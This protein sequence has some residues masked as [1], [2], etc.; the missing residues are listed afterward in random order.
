MRITEIQAKNIELT[1]AI[2]GYA[3]EKIMS[4]SKFTERYSPC[5]VAVELGKVTNHHNKGDFFRAE[6]NMN[7]PGALLRAEA[8]TDDLYKSIDQAKDD[9]KRQ[10]IDRKER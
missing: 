3:E 1:D 2:K 8:E 6:M 9:L 5:D 7:I 10:L 4:L